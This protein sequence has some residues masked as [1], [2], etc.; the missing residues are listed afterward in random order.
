MLSLTGSARCGQGWNLA[1]SLKATKMKAHAMTASRTP[2]IMK[3]TTVPIPVLMAMP[4]Q[5]Q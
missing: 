1:Q 3:M 2:R 5:S 4:V